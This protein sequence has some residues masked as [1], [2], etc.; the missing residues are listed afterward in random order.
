MWLKLKEKEKH[1][2]QKV[3]G[4]I[5]KGSIKQL[6]KSFWWKKRLNWGF[7]KHLEIE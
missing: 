4:Q 5:T 1:Q 7:V 2:Q 3:K 6:I